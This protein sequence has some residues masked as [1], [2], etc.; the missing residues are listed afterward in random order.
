M[1]RALALALLAL[2]AAPPAAASTT[3]PTPLASASRAP[4]ESSI[5]S[6]PAPLRS[7]IRANGYWR[8]G[9]PVPLSGLRLLTVTRRGFDGRSYTGRIVVNARAAG[10]LRGVFRRLYDLRFPIRSMDVEASTAR[11]R[12]SP[13]TAT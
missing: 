13:S 7:R 2:P 9:C 5:R 8:R 10:P 3:A 6:V 1:I 12:T 4:F 11:A